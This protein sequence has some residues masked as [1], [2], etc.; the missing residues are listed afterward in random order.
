MI[1]LNNNTLTRINDIVSKITETGKKCKLSE[2][3][4]AIRTAEDIKVTKVSHFV[5]DHCPC[6]AFKINGLEVEA[7]WLDETGFIEYWD[8]SSKAFNKL[9]TVVVESLEREFE[10][11]LENQE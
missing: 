5:D 9:I 2:M 10:V 11:Y 6:V 4:T 1:T 3:L 7:L 8:E